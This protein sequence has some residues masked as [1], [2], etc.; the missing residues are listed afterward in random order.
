MLCFVSFVPYMGKQ[1]KPTWVGFE[2]GWSFTKS[3]TKNV[4]GRTGKLIANV[5]LHFSWKLSVWTAGQENRFSD[6]GEQS[7]VTDAAVLGTWILDSDNHNQTFTFVFEFD[8]FLR[9]LCFWT[10]LWTQNMLLYWQ[11][12]LLNK[13]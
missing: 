13:K 10:E 7:S 4:D 9:I 3:L 8:L 5:L 11:R 2:L 12:K 6:I 1:S